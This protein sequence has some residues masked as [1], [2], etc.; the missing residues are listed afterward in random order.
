MAAKAAKL[1]TVPP[2]GQISIG[3]AWAGRQ[4]RVEE[5]NNNEI[6]ISSGNFVPDSQKDF[7]TEKSKLI[8]REFDSWEKQKPAKATDTKALFSKLKKKSNRGER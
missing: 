8:L 6:H 5:L 2:N 3:T 4:V 7:F 1:I